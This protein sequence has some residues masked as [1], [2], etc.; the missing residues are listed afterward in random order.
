MYTPDRCGS[1]SVGGGG[2]GGG[3]DHRSTMC[4]SKKYSFPPWKGLEFPTG[5][6]FCK[7]KQFKN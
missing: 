5:W 3:G 1:G 6:G 2:G 7:T 4:S